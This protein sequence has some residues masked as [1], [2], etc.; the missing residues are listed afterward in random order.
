M[1]ATIKY[2]VEMLL[3]SGIFTLLYKGLLEGRAG[4][5]GSRIYLIVSAIASATVPLLEIPI[6]PAEMVYMDLDLTLNIPENVTAEEIIPTLEAA[7]SAAKNSRL[8]LPAIYVSGVLI[9]LILA[10]IGIIR[11]TRLRNGS[12]IIKNE[13]MSSQ[14][15]RRSNPHSRSSGQSSL[16]AALNRMKRTS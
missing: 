16:G 4:Y 9:S 11:I 8:V 15:A 2:L 7:S 14:K 6:W 5:R 10:A 12:T 13:N 1:I 3:C